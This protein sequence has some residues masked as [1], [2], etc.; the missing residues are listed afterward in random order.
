MNKISDAFHLGTNDIEAISKLKR[1]LHDNDYKQNITSATIMLNMA[2][3]NI[4]DEAYTYW[5]AVALNL[6]E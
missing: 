4:G 6:P 5:S 2:H 1:I 3:D